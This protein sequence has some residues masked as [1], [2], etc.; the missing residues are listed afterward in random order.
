M[1]MPRYRLR[2][3]VGALQILG[4]R[5]IGGGDAKLTLEGGEAVVVGQAFVKLHKPKT[6]DYYA[7]GFAG[8]TVIRGAAFEKN[9]IEVK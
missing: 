6:H 1:R 8:A 7:T 9:Y 5:R 4:V 2:A 3:T